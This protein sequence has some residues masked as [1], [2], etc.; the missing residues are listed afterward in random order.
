M[1]KMNYHN[2]KP[3]NTDLLSQNVDILTQYFDFKSFV[4]VVWEDI[5]F[6]W[7]TF[8]VRIWI[9]K[10]SSII[11]DQVTWLEVAHLWAR[12][13]SFLRTFTR[14][15]I[16]ENTKK[17]KTNLG[18]SI[19]RWILRIEMKPQWNAAMECNRVLS[20]YCYISFQVFVLNLS[21]LTA[22]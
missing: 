15:K 18:F 6:H 7:S 17:T 11:G 20:V 12:L 8:T 1:Q 5:V 4:V 13:R 19:L 9:L 3:Q 10:K 16:L 2:E 22:N 21:A 14:K